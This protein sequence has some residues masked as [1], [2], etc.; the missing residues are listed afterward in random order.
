MSASVIPACA[1]TFSTAGIGPRP[2]ISGRIAAADEATIR[3][4][5]FRPSAAAFSADIT[6]SAAAPSLSGQAL[7][8]VT[9][10]SGSNTGLSW[11]STSTVV[12]AAARRPA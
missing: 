4:R 1:S 9:V 10:P 6:S 3:A 7:P 2:M 12:P 11:E 5:A 8:A